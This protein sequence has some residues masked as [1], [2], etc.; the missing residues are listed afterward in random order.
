MKIYKKVTNLVVWRKKYPDKTIIN[1]SI[2]FCDQ[3]IDLMKVLYNIAKFAGQK[4]SCYFT[5]NLI[6]SL[7]DDLRCLLVKEGGKIDQNNVKWLNSESAF[8]NSIRVGLIKNLR[9]I[10]PINF[11]EDAKKVFSVEIKNT[12]KE[13]M[14]NLKVYTI[15]EAIYAREKGEDTVEELKHFNTKTFPIYI[16]SNVE[17]LF[18]EN[19]ISPTLK[20]M[21]EFAQRE[22]GWTLKRIELLNVV[23]SKYN[24]MRCSSYLPLPESIAKKNE[25]I[26]VKD[27]DDQCL[28]WAVLS[29]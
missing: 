1:E 9:H 26:N 11:F 6:Q 23:I 13:K 21:D 17:K 7:R 10:E 3:N 20:D 29:A 25:C 24:P 14:H 4:Q 16:V 18:A 19:V 12:L 22:S 5:I 2:V 15:L 8:E 27:Y 28:K